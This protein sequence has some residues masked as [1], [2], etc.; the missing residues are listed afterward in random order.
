MPT[1]TRYCPLGSTRDFTQEGLWCVSCAIGTHSSNIYD[2]ECSP[3]KAGFFCD[4]LGSVTG[5]PC[6]INTYSTGGAKT[7]VL[8]PSGSITAKEGSASQAACVYP[9]TNFI[10]GGLT[11]AAIIP[12]SYLYLVHGRIH[13]ITYIR[14]TRVTRNLASI[15]MDKYEE[16]LLDIASI[17]TPP[18]STRSRY[19]ALLFIILGVGI[20]F[21]FTGLF[22]LATL[23]KIFFQG[24]IL[25][26]AIPQ[27]LPGSLVVLAKAW[28]RKVN[29]LFPFLQ[30]C[31][32]PF[33]LIFEAL[34][35]F[36]IDLSSVNLTCDGSLAPLELLL[37]LLILIFVAIEIES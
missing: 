4:A 3:C 24:M 8:C 31:F 30:D 14:S 32:T 13:R 36:H 27:F 26:R 15:L 11:L 21:L 37:N 25:H 2:S 19:K 23:L 5:T 7:C 9:M 12:L 33:L 22:L 20:L 1:L 35:Y 34:L 10:I 16:I 17:V 6:P 18:P 28:I 29:F